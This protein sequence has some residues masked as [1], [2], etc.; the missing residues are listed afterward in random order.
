MLHLS[1]VE[2]ETYAA[3][4]AIFSIPEIKENFAL[5]GGTSIALQLGHRTS[6]D[7][8]IFTSKNFN[9][10]ELETIV[11][12]HPEIAFDFVNS[13]R[14]MLFGYV[15]KIKCDFVL[16]PSILLQ[17]F[18]GY[19]NV[20]YFHLQD[21]AAMKMHTIC[22]RGKRKDFFDIY[23][24]IEN[25]G[26]PAML[27]WFVKKYDDSQLYFLWRSITYFDDADEDVEITGLPPY[28]KKWEE[29]KEFIKK[30]CV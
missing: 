14:T 18:I 30:T 6:I 2:K 7:L 10:K 3:L 23:V 1:T 19:E 11:S 24:L 20:N 12:S 5:A 27:E 16:E 28:T 15:N 9:P 17:P 4:T 25:F 21:I 13:N 22:G 29:I 26:W 8:D